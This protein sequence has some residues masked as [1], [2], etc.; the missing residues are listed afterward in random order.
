MAVTATCGAGAGGNGNDS[1]RSSRGRPGADAGGC[2][3][4]PDADE[5]PVS[6][7]ANYERLQE[8]IN[9]SSAKITAAV[10]C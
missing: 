10:R 6:T 2:E 5:R 1:G 7:S 4:Q 9:E 3:E 8:Q